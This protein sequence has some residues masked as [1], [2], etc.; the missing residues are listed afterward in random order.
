MA[1]FSAVYTSLVRIRIG[2]YIVTAA[3]QT[4]G[5]ALVD[6]VMDRLV[7]GLDRV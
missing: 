1:A 3:T 7:Q 5:V 6:P 2:G 4:F